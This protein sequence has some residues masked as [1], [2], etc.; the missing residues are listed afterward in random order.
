MIID[1]EKIKKIIQKKIGNNKKIE[2]KK[3]SGGLKNIIYLI[4]VDNKKYVFKSEPANKNFLLS[5]DT[6]LLKWDTCWSW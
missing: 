5:I 3:L 6:N 1:E 2:L 4:E